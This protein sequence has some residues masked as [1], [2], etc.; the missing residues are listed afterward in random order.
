MCCHRAKAASQSKQQEA[1]G[2]DSAQAPDAAQSRSSP[3]DGAS[4]TPTEGAQTAG[5]GTAEPLQAARAQSDSA[6]AHKSAAQKG[7]GGNRRAKAKGQTLPVHPIA[8]ADARSAGANAP[9]HPRDVA[10]CTTSNRPRVL[11]VRRPKRHFARSCTED[12]ASLHAS[13]GQANGVQADA[14]IQQQ[15][16]T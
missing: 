5:T 7:S 14:S 12:S 3:I 1:Q 15:L 13:V 2:L 11:E 8:S 16:H 4:P 6:A 10:P 9:E